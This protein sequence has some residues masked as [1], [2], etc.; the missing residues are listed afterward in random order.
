[1][2]MAM[3]DG[4]LDGDESSKLERSRQKYGISIEQHNQLLEGMKRK[5]QPPALKPRGRKGPSLKVEH[6]HLVTLREN[7]EEES[8]SPAVETD[9]A[10]VETE[11]LVKSRMME[12]VRLRKLQ[13]EEQAAKLVSIAQAPA[14]AEAVGPNN[15]LERLRQRRQQRL[16]LEGDEFALGDEA[17]AVPPSPSHPPPPEATS[18]TPP[19]LV[20]PAQ[21]LR[22]LAAA[23]SPRRD[24]PV[25]ERLRLKRERTKKAQAAE[26]ARKEA[27]V[28]AAAEAAAATAAAEKAAAEKAEK[29]EQEALVEEEEAE[30]RASAVAGEGP[31][32]DDW[33]TTGPK[34]SREEEAAAANA[35]ERDVPIDASA[36]GA[37]QQPAKAK[38][39]VAAAGEKAGAAVE[40]ELLSALAYR[41]LMEMAM[42]DGELDEDERRKL[43]RSRQKYRIT[44]EQH[45]QLLQGMNKMK[46][47]G[48]AANKMIQDGGAAGS[49]GEDGKDGKDGEDGGKATASTSP[50]S[51][52]KVLALA[53]KRIADKKAQ[54]ALAGKGLAEERGKGVVDGS[55]GEDGEDE[56]AQEVKEEKANKEKQQQQQ[57]QQ[58]EAEEGEEA[59]AMQE[60]VHEENPVV[61]KG[62]VGGAGNGAKSGAV[63]KDDGAVAEAKHKDGHD[64]EQQQAE[65]NESDPSLDEVY[66]SLDS[67]EEGT[68]PTRP[69]SGRK[70]PMQ[71]L[72]QRAGGLFSKGSRTKKDKKGGAKGGV[73]GGEGETAEETEQREEEEWRAK[74]KAEK[75]EKEARK[76][77]GALGEAGGAGSA[78][79]KDRQGGGVGGGSSSQ[80]RARS[81]SSVP[82]LE[83]DPSLGGS[84]LGSKRTVHGGA[85]IPPL[86]PSEELVQR[87]HES[88]QSSSL[89]M[90]PIDV[91]NALDMDHNGKVGRL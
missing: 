30:G 37:Q 10:S 42:A 13:R 44:M 18:P 47:D 8:R 29:E 45:Q 16:R 64:G 87:I 4:S 25:L 65:N 36:F 91:F 61:M 39:E 19:V 21:V 77:Q 50:N 54:T 74:V 32:S 59:E 83:M 20:A 11:D 90:R 43:E 69:A 52:M 35:A 2:E 33:F 79:S 28:E 72:R 7:K 41:D 24:S 1:M 81:V 38:E 73:K 68:T 3:V 15:T 71:K 80:V 14:E 6:E 58:L 62:E 48:G 84:P 49:G 85:S 70:S 27:A 22:P 17:M 78:S 46:Q 31:V 88:I 82:G 23:Q 60:K 66:R 53:R 34:V 63:A 51:K 56:R 5:K 9:A 55:N 12:R 86:L 57:Q 89:H 67:A 26:Q 76:Q 40:E 75:A